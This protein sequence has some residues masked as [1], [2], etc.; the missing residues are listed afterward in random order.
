MKDWIRNVLSIR[1]ARRPAPVGQ[2]PVVGTDIQR[3]EL[4][5]AVT[6]RI[7][8]ELWDW[9]VLSGWRNLPVATDRRRGMRMAVAVVMRMVLRHRVAVFMPVVP[10]FGL[11]EQKEKHQAHQQ[12]QK[13]LVRPSL[14]LEGLGQEVQKRSGHQGPC[15]QAQHVL[16]VAAQNAKTEPSRH[17]DAADARHQSAHQNRQ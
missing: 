14:T 9:L 12:G 15:G 4:K 17:P 6:H 3:R 1:Q 7:P 8:G 5:M 11:V 2:V 16:G 13:Q 10:Q